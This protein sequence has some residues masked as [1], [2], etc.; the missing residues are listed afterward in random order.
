MGRKGE[1]LA[2]IDRIIQVDKRF[3]R[4]C[5]P[6]FYH[7]KVPLDSICVVKRENVGFNNTDAPQNIDDV[8]SAFRVLIFTKRA[9]QIHRTETRE[10]RKDALF[11]YR[12][13]FRWEERIDGID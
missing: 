4:V 8:K 9:F 1:L 2:V 10:F 3:R 12:I 13:H 6:P 7:R 11:Y 5:K